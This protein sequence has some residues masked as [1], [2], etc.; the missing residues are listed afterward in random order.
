MSDWLG[1][2]WKFRLI[3]MRTTSIGGCLST[4]QVWNIDKQSNRV[5]AKVQ[6]ILDRKYQEQ[7]RL[8]SFHEERLQDVRDAREFCEERAASYEIQADLADECEEDI[9]GG[10]SY[11]CC[12]ERTGERYMGKAE[13]LGVLEERLQNVDCDSNF[14]RDTHFQLSSIREEVP[15]MFAEIRK[16][17]SDLGDPVN[18]DSEGEIDNTGHGDDVAYFKD[19]CSCKEYGIGWARKICTRIPCLYIMQ[20]DDV[21]I[22]IGISRNLRKRFKNHETLLRVAT[23]EDRR[24][25]TKV[26][27]Y[28]VDVQET[29]DGQWKTL[30]SIHKY[31]PKIVETVERIMIRHFRGPQLLNKVGNCHYSNP[32][33]LPGAM[34]QRKT[35]FYKRFASECIVSAPL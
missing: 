10:D 11:K 32:K 6:N 15:E 19:L 3:P 33:T 9:L 12:Y 13:E 17:F 4:P 22:Y 18:D 34:G 8:A 7:Q 27:V 28:A 25:V 1:G 14:L 26:T 23:D 24:D 31:S 21:P 20:I 2:E 35:T 30:E 29:P 5:F 16:A